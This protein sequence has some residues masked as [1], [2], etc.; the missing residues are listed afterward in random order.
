M[1]VAFYCYN[2]RLSSGTGN[3]LPAGYSPPKVLL[4]WRQFLGGQSVLIK[5]EELSK[6]NQKG[7]STM[8]EVPRVASHFNMHTKKLNR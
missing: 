2:Q 3:V 7:V 5:G 1:P 8:Y 4:L 6:K